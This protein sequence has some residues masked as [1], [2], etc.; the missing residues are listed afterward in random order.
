MESFTQYIGKYKP[1]NSIFNVDEEKDNS[2]NQVS[3]EEFTLNDM[4]DLPCRFDS[5][6]DV[7]KLYDR[8]LNNPEVFTFKVPAKFKK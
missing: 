1:P 8:I 2:E 3:I 5:F 6:G 7:I 4:N